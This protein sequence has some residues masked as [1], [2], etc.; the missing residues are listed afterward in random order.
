MKNNNIFQL[1]FYIV[2]MILFFTSTVMMLLV[3]LKQS[4]S[5]FTPSLI[6]F[7]I[8]LVLIVIDTIMHRI[9]KYY[10][11]DVLGKNISYKKLHFSEKKTLDK[12]KKYVSYYIKEKEIKNIKNFFLF[13]IYY[14]DITKK[15]MQGNEILK[16]TK[17]Q[18]ILIPN[19]F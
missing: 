6:V 10:S 13:K 2:E 7:L 16:T 9:T 12:N 1:A 11:F 5:L 3:N 14:G 4:Y 8:G 18:K 17:V 15:Q 19:Y